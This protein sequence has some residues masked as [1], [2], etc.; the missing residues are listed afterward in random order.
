MFILCR[1]ERSADLACRPTMG[2]VLS[3]SPT[4]KLHKAKST[5]S[6]MSSSGISYGSL[7]SASDMSNG[8][9]KKSHGLKK[10]PVF[11]S[12]FGLKKFSSL[13]KRSSLITKSSEDVESKVTTTTGLEKSISCFTISSHKKADSGSIS[14]STL[15][16]DAKQNGVVHCRGK[17]TISL[18]KKSD[19]FPANFQDNNNGT[20]GKSK[21]R[22]IQASTSELLTC[23]GVFVCQR[24]RRIQRLQVVEVTNWLKMVDRSLL[25]QGWQ[26]IGFIN[27]AN[28]VF[29]YMLLR[30]LVDEDIEDEKQLK[31]I[32][33]T[34]LYLSYSY[35]GNEISYPLKPFLTENNRDRFWTRCVSII[36][37]MSDKM[38]KI[39]ADP[40]F[41][42]MIFSELKQF[43]PQQPEIT[44]N[45]TQL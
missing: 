24:C 11:F 30:D 7:S 36:N 17:A 3:V 2:T 35:M 23:I 39:N 14:S 16:T 20:I 22:V 34:C 27:P 21:K 44:L 10:P 8:S 25:F 18:L 43:L 5:P 32:V 40:F 41:F 29:V 33:L 6:S 4:Q 28:L 26:D 15:P 19:T 31:A 45:S 12:T 9:V 13:G 38:L 1:S 37:K 42:T